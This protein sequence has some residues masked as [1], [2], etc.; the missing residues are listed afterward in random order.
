M[1]KE[2]LIRVAISQGDYNGVGPEVILKALAND[3]IIELFTPIIFSDRRLIEHT[4]RVLE[5][6]INH[7]H[8]VASAA[9]AK[10]GKVN[11]VDLHLPSF[12]IDAGHPNRESGEAAVVSL[13][14]AV[15]SVMDG[16]CD[17][18]VTAP[19]SKEAVQSDDFQF[20]GHTEFLSHQ[21]GEEYK[22]QMILFNDALRVALVTT[23]LP[24]SEI[25][26]HITK[27]NVAEA[28]KSL[29]K[30]L[31]RDFGIERPKIAVLSLN[32]HCGDGGLLGNE[33]ENEIIPG[34]EICT[35]EG[36]MVFGPY[37]ADGFFGS[38]SYRKF[39]GVVA[40]YHD[41]GL[42]P[43]K[44]L[45]RESGV[46]FT[47]ALPFVRTSPDHGTACDIAWKG[48]ARAESMRE[49]IYQAIDI[50]RNRRNYDEASANPLMK[51]PKKNSGKNS[52]KERT[53]KENETEQ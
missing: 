44:A 31:R 49:A 51:A 21:A 48:V 4:R 35:E 7:L 52:D 23:H 42:A 38:D 19:I 45:A 18:L 33:E 15:E 36:L 30:T 9:D 1:S 41:Q 29:E 40:M 14:A 27:E 11:V 22:A 50:Y 34:V 16:E 12:T 47:A 53:K 25:S 3:T 2:R 6:P 43:F 17:I 8:Y 39:D 13:R 24:L 20:E 10:A 28:A 37:A 5:I 46:N 32:P 26:Q